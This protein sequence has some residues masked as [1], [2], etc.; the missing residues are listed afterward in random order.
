MSAWAAPGPGS[1]PEGYED[2][3]HGP[4]LLIFTIVLTAVTILSIVA[5]FWSRSLVNLEPGQTGLYWWD[6]WTAL[7]SVVSLRKSPRHPIGANFCLAKP[8]ILARFAILFYMFTVGLG[9]H[10]DT[11][12]SEI[13]ERIQQLIF[14]GYFLYTGAVFFVKE[15]AIFFLNR[16]FPRHANPTWFN[17]ALVVTHVLNVAWFIGIFLANLLMCIPVAKNWDRTLPG[18]CVRGNA[19]WIANGSTSVFID[20]LI[21]LLPLPKIW[22]LQMSNSRKSALSIIFA[23]GYCA[24]II[25]CGRLIT[26]LTATPSSMMDATYGFIN[27]LYWINAEAPVL[28]L[29]VCLPAMLP[30]GRHV[31][32]TYFVPLTSRFSTYISSTR[33]ASSYASSKTRSGRFSTT[34]NSEDLEMVQTKE[35]GKV[36]SRSSQ[37]RILEPS[38]PQ[39]ETCVA[40]AQEVEDFLLREPDSPHQRYSPGTLEEGMLHEAR[41]V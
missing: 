11:L 21:L 2:E 37:H 19:V 9:Y 31:R 18:Y 34:V 30:L 20:L 23:L 6:D 28:L 29:S 39:R 16:V 27:V 13:Y 25:S 1:W 40:E 17:A 35:L 8:L 41:V 36:H 3:N 15:S 12:P 22:S 4:G 24:I 5:R 38:R 32:T 10:A 7:I 14:V 33:L 26:V